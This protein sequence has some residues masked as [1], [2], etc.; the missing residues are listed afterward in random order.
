MDVPVDTVTAYLDPMLSPKCASEGDPPPV[1]GSG[2]LSGAVTGQLLWDGNKEFERAG[3]TNVPA[4][5]SEDEKRVAYVFRLA[6]DPT[7]EFQLP[8]AGAAVTPESTGN[9]GFDYQLTVGG[10]NVTLYALAG[11]ENRKLSPPKFI[12]YA[13]GIAKGVSSKP[14]Q[15]TSDVFIKVDIPL[16]HA[17]ALDVTGPT[18]TTKGPDRIVAS[19][20]VRVGEQGYAI[21]PVGK[22]TKLLPI[23]GNINFIGLP[24]LTEALNGSQ[25]VVS[26]EAV[27]GVA[28]S[29]PRSVTAALATTVSGPA[30]P[31]SDFVEVPKLLIP[32][33][34][35]AWTGTELAWAWLPGGESVDLSVLTLST[36]GGLVNWT[37]AAPPGV[38][39][40]KLPDLSQL[41][42]GLS[43]PITIGVSVA[44]IVDFDYGSLRYRQLGDRGWNAYATYVFYAH[45]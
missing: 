16:D 44:H 41:G 25:Y 19:T 27:T 8:S 3:W 22:Q 32:A 30:I 24:P 6:S 11:L 10:G 42:L 17:V 20:A 1:G 18:P 5:Q 13:M 26:A 34:N 23:S 28:E 39:Q 14:G 40:T 21:F 15:V 29:T 2:S 43:G 38:T 33:D 7:N 45:L 4:P 37:V 35:G 36:G 9:V 31:I 12:A